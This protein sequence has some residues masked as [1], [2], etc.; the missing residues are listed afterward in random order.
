MPTI[1]KVIAHRGASAYAPENTLAAFRRAKS[2]GAS[3]VELDVRLT[4]CGEVIV[5]HDET[6]ERTSNG[7]GRV[8]ETPYSALA[9]LDAGAWF[10]SEFAGEKI[11]TLIEVINCLAECQLGANIELKAVKG[12][13]QA[14]AENT[15]KILNDNWPDHLPAP[16]LSSLSTDALFAI[17]KIDQSCLLGLVTYPWREDWLMQTKA[18]NCYSYHVDEAELTPE[19]IQM[20]LVQGLKLFAYTVNDPARASTLFSYGVN[21]VFSD[22]PDKILVSL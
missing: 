1:P 22:C 8:D 7:T 2:L 4:A 3:W 15:M 10:S 5:F 19:R 9:R 21:G 17:G 12:Q 20:I 13:E 18:L 11:P 6:L 14:L 16:I